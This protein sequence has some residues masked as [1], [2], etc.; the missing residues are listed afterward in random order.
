M[1]ASNAHE[2]KTA[3]PVALAAALLAQQLVRRGVHEA[4]VAERSWNG[5]PGAVY[6][7][8]AEEEACPQY[9]PATEHNRLLYT[10]IGNGGGAHAHDL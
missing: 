3:V 9:V 10:A 1:L 8:R 5:A 6:G 4:T 7:Q 2:V